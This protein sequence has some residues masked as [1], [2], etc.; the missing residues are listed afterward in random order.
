MG[1]RGSGRAELSGLRVGSSARLVHADL[2]PCCLVWRR[3]APFMTNGRTTTGA[4]V[5]LD[6]QTQVRMAEAEVM[7]ESGGW[8]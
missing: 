6:A 2:P 8:W 7:G 1:G 5:H 3:Q 4:V